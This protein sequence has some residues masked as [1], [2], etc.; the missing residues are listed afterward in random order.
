MKKKFVALMALVAL[1]LTLV[2]TN[3]TLVSEVHAQK[4]RVDK[5]ELIEATADTDVPFTLSGRRW[6]SK[7]EWAQ[8][9]GRC[10]T[11]LMSQAQAQAVQE[12]INIHKENQRL[13]TGSTDVER[14]PGSVTIQVRF[15]VINQGAGIGNGDIPQSMIDAQIQVLNNAYSGTAPGG[16][17]FNTPFRFVLAG[18]TRTTNAAWY[19]ADAGSPEE[20]A[21][22][23]ALRVGGANVLNFY[24]TNAGD[25]QLLGWATLPSDY[26]S[27]PS[28]DG[29]V[30]LFA[31]LPGGFA[32]P[33][34]Q[35]D[36]GTH[37]VGHWLGLLHTFDG[38]CDKSTGGDFV[39]DTRPEAAE[40]YD[41]VTTQRSCPNIPRGYDPVQ[42]FMDYT[43]DSCMYKFTAGQSERMDVLAAIYRGL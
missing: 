4:A 36:T 41:C 17:G 16:T 6:A 21:M 22:K 1:G 19:N 39:W 5:T 34:N 15:H 38:G 42:N 30:V 40:T 13:V 3:N 29:V 8:T 32:A 2:L 43:D 28:Y 31:S 24:T 11:P 27:F 18:V 14:A 37:E 23:V 26:S 35:G 25:G 9:G 20:V 33:Y 10:R 12:Q 7:Q